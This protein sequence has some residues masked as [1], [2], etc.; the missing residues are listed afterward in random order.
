MK[1]E[2][3][4][5]FSGP[6]VRAI[7][8][9]SKT[10]TRR[11]FN[12]KRCTEPGC[13]NAWQVPGIDGTFGCPYGSEDADPPTRL[14]VRETWR[15]RAG[16]YYYAADFAPADV[17]ALKWKPSIHMPRA[18]SRLLL[19]VT[20]TRLERLQDITEEDARAEGTPAAFW[21][22]GNQHVG[23]CYRAA[24]PALWDMTYGEQAPWKSN[25]VVW[26]VSFRRVEGGT[27]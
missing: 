5:L 9:G 25:P 3:P 7:L 15:K 14:W 8:D 24:F 13:L 26:V 22:V 4:I 18:A 6:M 23:P 10:Q 20:E 17:A 12:P 2:L 16:L 27:T 19:E 21:K 11:V 1:A